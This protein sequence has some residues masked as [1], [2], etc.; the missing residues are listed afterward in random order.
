MYLKSLR[1]SRGLTQEDVGRMIGV[2]RARISEIE[3]DP[4]ALGLTQLLRL[5]HVLGARVGLEVDEARR[6]DAGKRRSS[7]GGEW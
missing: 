4:S 5:V 3:R 1:K 6:H 2:S 7:S